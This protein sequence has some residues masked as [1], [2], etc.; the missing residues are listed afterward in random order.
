MCLRLITLSIVLLGLV[1]LRTENTEIRYLATGPSFGKDRIHVAVKAA[2]FDFNKLPDY[3][4]ERSWIPSYC[5][6]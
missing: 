3:L 2:V 1:I 6:V 5:K 4:I